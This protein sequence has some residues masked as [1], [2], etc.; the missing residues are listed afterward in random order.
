MVGGPRY[1]VWKALLRQAADAGLL[2]STVDPDA[3]A[4]ASSQLVAG[5]V[6]EWAQGLLSLEEMT[7]RN[8]YGLALA[9]LA[10]ATDRSRGQ[11]ERRMRQAEVKLQRH[12]RAMLLERLRK[13]ELDDESRALLADQLA[14]LTSDQEVS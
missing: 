2:Q 13:G 11:L 5:N 10:I 8:E 9:L 7:A 14:R 12:W 1:L 4:I 6:S 3:F